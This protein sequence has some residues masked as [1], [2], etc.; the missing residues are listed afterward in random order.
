MSF[1]KSDKQKLQELINN[2]EHAYSSPAAFADSKSNKI[3]LPSRLVRATADVVSQTYENGILQ[4]LNESE[5]E[6]LLTSLLKAVGSMSES[7]T[8]V[9]RALPENVPTGTV[10]KLEQNSIEL[11]ALKKQREALFD[12]TQ[13]VL[14]S[15]QKL[16]ADKEELE[17][18]RRQHED[19]LAAK[20][21][22]EKIDLDTLRLQVKELET[23]IGPQRDE[24]QRLQ[25][26]AAAKRAEL[27][28]IRV[29]TIAAQEQLDRDIPQA[30]EMFTSLLEVSNNLVAALE[31]H[32]RKYESSIQKAAAY[33]SGKAEEGMTL[34]RDLEARVAEVDIVEKD[35]SSLSMALRKYAESNDFVS[36]NIPTVINLTKEKLSRVRDLLGETD[37]ELQTALD[38]HRHAHEVLQT[39]S[40][41]TAT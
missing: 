22:L 27:D 10:A 15:D 37:A 35:M 3:T 18:L 28:S 1:T 25:S 30:R 17:R 21:E 11:K 14:E 20:A 13:L 4:S 29:A 6:L 8:R 32:L 40:F 39:S 31:P 26:L 7:L 2:I 23:E 16:V 19:L 24:M 41:Q 9:I 5:V 34:K 36:V 12:S 38:R 33:L